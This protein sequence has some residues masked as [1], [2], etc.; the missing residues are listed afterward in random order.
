M[1]FY[2]IGVFSN[3]KMCNKDII[4]DEILLKFGKSASEP[5]II[6][7]IKDLLNYQLKLGNSLVI[8]QSYLKRFH[9]VIYQDDNDL[10]QFEV[11]NVLRQIFTIYTNA[12]YDT[13]IGLKKKSIKLAK[14]IKRRRLELVEYWMKFKLNWIQL[15]KYMKNSNL[16]LNFYPQ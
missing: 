6:V 13:L 15:P 8:V 10:L 9:H 7:V 3:L 1:E 11:R 2:L 14:E 4:P 12:T 5:I 16:L